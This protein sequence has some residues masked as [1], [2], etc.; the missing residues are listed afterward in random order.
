VGSDE[1]GAASC[2]DATLAIAS[3]ADTAGGKCKVELGA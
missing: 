1:R 2:H 3:D